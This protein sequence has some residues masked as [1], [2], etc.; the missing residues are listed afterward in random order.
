MLDSS[1]P[2]LL[3]GN[4]PSP[5]IDSSADN[6]F[7]CCSRVQITRAEKV[8]ITSFLGKGERREGEGESVDTPLARLVH[9][10]SF[11]AR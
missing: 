2:S 1:L 11:G 8:M 6:R 9:I 5:A 10:I 4:T 7:G 3:D